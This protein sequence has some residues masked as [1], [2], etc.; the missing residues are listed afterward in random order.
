VNKILLTTI[1]QLILV[2]CS[3]DKV[4]NLNCKNESHSLTIFIDPEKN[5]FYTSEF[6]MV[7]SQKLDRVDFTGENKS[8][9]LY[10]NLKGKTTIHSSYEKDEI[11]YKARFL[12]TGG[13]SSV[14]EYYELNRTSLE[15]FVSSRSSEVIDK[16]TETKKVEATAR[17]YQC[18]K[19]ERI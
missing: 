16:E 14:R 8:I 3:S 15:L 11:Y 1:C 10:K 17:N 12:K 9:Y 4:I 18:E 5:M 6:K 13:E 7:D 2:S 19:K